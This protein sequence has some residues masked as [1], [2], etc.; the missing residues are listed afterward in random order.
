M[1]DPKIYLPISII[2]VLSIVHLSLSVPSFS[3]IIHFPRFLYLSALLAILT[4]IVIY[5]SFKNKFDFDNLYKLTA[6]SVLFSFIVLLAGIT[7]INQVYTTKTCETSSYKV[8]GYKGRYTSGLG[9]ME[10]DKIKANQWI[11]SIVK[12]D[13]IETF[14][15]D[16]DISKD[17]RVTIDLELQFCKGLLGTE[18]LNLEQIPE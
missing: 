3:L 8:V 15:L 4:G 2:V 5:Y 17:N 18:F 14:V 12:N 6:S 13:E 7:L 16:K 11:M 1:N 10:K 9:V